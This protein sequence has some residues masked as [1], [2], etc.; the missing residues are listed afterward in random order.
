[1]YWMYHF[2]LYVALLPGTDT[3]VVQVSTTARGY[4]IVVIFAS[5]KGT[6]MFLSERLNTNT[7][8]TTSIRPDLYLSTPFFPVVMHH[9]EIDR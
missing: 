8:D 3:L 7:N 4:L 6:N 5:A 9:S 2:D 1:M